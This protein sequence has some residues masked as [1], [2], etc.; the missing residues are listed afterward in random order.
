MNPLL[1]AAAF[2]LLKH[3]RIECMNLL[4]PPRTPALNMKVFKRKCHGLPLL[5]PRNTLFS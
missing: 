2:N 5:N 4:K 1:A 3:T